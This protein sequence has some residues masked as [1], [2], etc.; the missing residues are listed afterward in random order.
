M[1]DFVSNPVDKKR[2]AALAENYRRLARERQWMIAIEAIKPARSH[3][4]ARPEMSEL[5]TAYDD[6]RQ[7]GASLHV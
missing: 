2:Y 3:S 4:D 6:D 7:A 5:R 1:A